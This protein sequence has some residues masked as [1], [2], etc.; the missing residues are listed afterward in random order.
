MRPRIPPFRACAESSFAAA[1]SEGL[2]DGLRIGLGTLK[3]EGI[4]L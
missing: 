2:G 3:T 1:Q 4:H